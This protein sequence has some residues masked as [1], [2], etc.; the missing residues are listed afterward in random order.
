MK[1]IEPF[2]AFCYGFVAGALVG[3]WCIYMI[4]G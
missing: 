3:M 2:V 1:T 4:A